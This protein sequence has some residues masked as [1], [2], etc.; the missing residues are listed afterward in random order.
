MGCFHQK[1][2]RRKGCKKEREF[3]TG[4][5]Y[6]FVYNNIVCSRV[7]HC[8]SLI[9]VM[10]STKARSSYILHVVQHSIP[11]L[12]AQRYGR[13]SIRFDRLSCL[14]IHVQAIA[15]TCK[16]NCLYMYKQWIRRVAYENR[17][18]LV[19]LRTQFLEAQWRSQEKTGNRQN[20]N[21]RQGEMCLPTRRA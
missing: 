11:L 21:N 2:H 5:Q 19:L 12:W 14:L 3:L 8:S 4:Q 17:Y 1:H 20:E 16:S 6:F 15:Y 18:R 7:T 10:F 13:T 9:G